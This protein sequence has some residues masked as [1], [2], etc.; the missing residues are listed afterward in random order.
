MA[1]ARVGSANTSYLV[2][3][4]VGPGV[5]NRTWSLNMPVTAGHV[6]VPALPEPWLH[7]RCDQCTGHRRCFAERT[8]LDHVPVAAFRGRRRSG[9]HTSVNG[10]G[11]TAAA[12]V[13]WNGS[14]R[15]TTYVSATRLQAAIPASD[16][17]SIADA[18]VTVVTPPPGGGTSAPATFRATGPPSLSVN[19]TSVAPGGT[20]TLTLTDGFGGQ[21]DWLSFALTTAANYSY[22][23]FVY[24][25]SGTTSRTWT[26]TAPSTAGNY[27]FRSFRNGS[28]TRSATSPTVVVGGSSGG[29]NPTP[30][31]TSLS[32]S[33]AA[34]GSASFNLTVNGTSFVSSST[35]RWN[36]ADRPTTFLSATQLRATIPAT[37]VASVGTASV[38][39]FTPAPGGGTSSSLTFTIAQ[40][41]AA[42]RRQRNNGRRRRRRHHHVDELPARV[43]G[44]AR[45]R[46]S[47]G[48]QH[49]LHPLHLRWRRHDHE[50]MDGHRADDARLVSVPAVPE[51]RLHARRHEPDGRRRK[52]AA[53]CDQVAQPFSGCFISP[54]CS[55]GTC[56]RAGRSRCRRAPA[57]RRSRRPAC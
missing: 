40:A 56:T 10:F 53:R 14:N 16:I 42:A 13:R 18:A 5:V 7:A 20:V 29:S 9:V 8:S 33:S 6:R 28:Y 25:G 37:D 31:V 39:V 4:Y 46:A 12:V 48:A 23:S 45:V 44:L 27:E 11:Y 21:T 30:A 43:G 19:A 52:S 51:Q 3:T 41:A 36:G 49:E 55:R 50:N 1:L 26:V 15:P 2:Y 34:A 24:V 57:T 22:S 32:P 47:L 17:A 35:V 54:R 38:T